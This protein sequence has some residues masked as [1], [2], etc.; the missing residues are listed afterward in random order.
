VIPIVWIICVLD[1][2]FFVHVMFV[3]LWKFYTVLCPIELTTLSCFEITASRLV[4]GGRGKAKCK[5]LNDIVTVHGPMPIEIPK[6]HQAPVGDN[7]SM[8][9]SKVD[10][11]VRC[12]CELHHDWLTM[13]PPEQKDI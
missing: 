3:L 2:I 5:K 11:I 7:A 8:F 10:A 13:V 9:I 6:G 4:R 1:C 12:M